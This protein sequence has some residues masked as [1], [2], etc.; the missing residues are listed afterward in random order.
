MLHCDLSTP[1]RACR[2]H[3][4][5]AVTVA[6]VDFMISIS[7]PEIS[8]F[9]GFFRISVNL[10][11]LLAAAF[12]PSAALTGTADYFWEEFVNPPE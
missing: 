5:G 7:C 1:S 11:V 9:P 4:L 12:W 3:S 8:V 2:T 6:Y 10:S